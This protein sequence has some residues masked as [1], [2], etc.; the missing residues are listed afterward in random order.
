[1]KRCEFLA[2]NGREESS[3]LGEDA[4]VRFDLGLR[5]GQNIG[6]EGRGTRQVMELGQF[7]LENRS[8]L[9]GCRTV[10]RGWITGPK[11]ERRIYLHM[12]IVRL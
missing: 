7:S 12:N 6:L 3:D 8:G 4:V 2:E 1:L 5:R 11:D 10:R 9:R